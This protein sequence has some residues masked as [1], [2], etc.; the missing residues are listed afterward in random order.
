MPWF[1]VRC[2]LN[3][4]VI[5]LPSVNAELRARLKVI[6]AWKDWFCPQ[7]VPWPSDLP[8]RQ[9]ASIRYRVQPS[10]RGESMSHFHF[11]AQIPIRAALFYSRMIGEE[12]NSTGDDKR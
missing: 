7:L 4:F 8:V 5:A 3:G 10:P 9:H 1:S 11:V 6:H 2:E 12:S